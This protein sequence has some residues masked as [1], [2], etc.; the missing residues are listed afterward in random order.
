MKAATGHVPGLAVV[1]VGTRKDSQTYVRSKKKACA[2]AGIE[3]FGVDFPEDCTELE[4]LQAVEE[5]NGDPR[6]HGVLVQLPLPKVIPPQPIVNHCPCI[7]ICVY[8]YVFIS[9]SWFWGFLLYFSG[10]GERGD[11]GLMQQFFVRWNG[12]WGLGGAGFCST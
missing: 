8:M 6:V 10:G 2:E 3:S 4:V 5:L 9:L 12:G 1:L 11:R 7:D